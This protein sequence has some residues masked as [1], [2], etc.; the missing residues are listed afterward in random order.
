MMQDEY[1]LSVMLTDTGSTS[2]KPQI[3]LITHIYDAIHRPVGNAFIPVTSNQG[4][5]QTARLA[6]DEEVLPL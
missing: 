5:W 2:P 3:P 6:D 1:V 4:M